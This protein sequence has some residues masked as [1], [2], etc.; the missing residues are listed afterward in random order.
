MRTRCFLMAIRR[1]A[2]VKLPGNSYIEPVEPLVPDYLSDLEKVPGRCYSPASVIHCPADVPNTICTGCAMR[3]LGEYW[4]EFKART[5][6][7]LTA[8]QYRRKNPLSDDENWH[9]ANA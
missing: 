2:R 8:A 6:V 1:P 3:E 7:G 4:D 5:N 9:R